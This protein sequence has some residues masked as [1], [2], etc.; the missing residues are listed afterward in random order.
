MVESRPGRAQTDCIVDHPSETSHAENLSAAERRPQRHGDSGRRDRHAGSALD[1]PPQ[2]HHRRAAGGQCAARHGI[3]DPRRHG[4]DRNLQPSLQR[5]RRRVHDRAGAFPG[6]QRPAD[7]GRR[8]L[9][10]GA[11][12]TRHHPLYRPAAF[13]DLRR[14]LRAHHGDRAKGRRRSQCPAR[15]DRGPHGGRAG[16]CRCRRRGDLTRNL[17]SERR[18]GQTRT[19]RTSCAGLAPSTT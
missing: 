15:R 1:R 16:A 7:R 3:A 10:A 6:R 14:T 13:P 19:S 2:S 9:R 17:R 5:G 8:D 11:R 18:T 12:Q 4:G